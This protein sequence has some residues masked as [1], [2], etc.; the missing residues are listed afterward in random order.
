MVVYQKRSETKSQSHVY[1]LSILIF[2][3]MSGPSHRAYTIA[4]PGLRLSL[5][6]GCFSSLQAQ[7]NTTQKGKI[8]PSQSQ[9]VCF[10][11][12]KPETQLTKPASLSLAHPVRRIYYEMANPKYLT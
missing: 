4:L 9:R 2:V 8:K 5:N 3:R 10:T 12:P 6:F 7:H 1:P 11:A